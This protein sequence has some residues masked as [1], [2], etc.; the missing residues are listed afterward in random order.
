MRTALILLF[1]L[2]V[3]SLPAALLP[4]WYLNESKTAQYIVAHPTLGPLLNRL[5]FFDVVASPWYSAIYLML[6][7]SLVGCITPRSIELVNQWRAKPGRAPK[8]LARLPH[9]ASRTVAGDSDVVAERIRIA[10]R[11]K[12]FGGWRTV[13]RSEK[14]GAVT[15]SAERGYLREVGNLIFHVAVLG[16][17]FTMAIG[18]MFGYTGSVL[19][20]EGD[21]FCS[22]APVT[23]D[24]FAPGRMV[25]GTNMA[26]FCVNVEKFE[27]AYDDQGLAKYYR[28]Q[29][30]V[31]I[32]DEAGSTHFTQQMLNINDP[33]RLSGQRLYLLGHG[34]VPQ[35]SI[36]FPNGDVRAYSAPFEPKDAQF[37]SQGV[38]KITDP[39]GYSG[40]ETR[41]NQLAIVGIFAPSGIVS[42]GVLTS[43]YPDLLAPAVAV[44]VYRGDLGLDHGAPQSIFAIDTK[45]VDKGLLTSQ[46][47]SNL[48]VGQS[49]TLDDGTVITFT[50]AKNFVS[51]QTSY[52]PVQGFALLFAI[53]LIGGIL[54]SLTIKRR[55]VWYRVTPLALDGADEPTLNVSSSVEVG[56]LARTDQAGYGSEFDSLVSL[57]GGTDP[58][59]AMD[60]LPEEADV[61]KESVS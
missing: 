49:M 12:G 31:Q 27:A 45:Q 47:R 54:T 2:A 56:G 13:V 44:E 52:D 15:V 19:V 61:T 39:P 22:S 20:T 5:G 9:H 11:H 8:N 32:G 55:R 33:L 18:S 28:A 4:Q 25:D 42:N 23:Y 35:F 60:E 46:G 30:G 17:L 26:P 51:L 6:A 24:N 40:A 37:T 38:V 36:R 58:T 7:I 43:G 41:K 14:S 21:G 3:G 34:Y 53:L 59:T 29:L 50:G 48:T 1:L 16:L 57:V 10:L